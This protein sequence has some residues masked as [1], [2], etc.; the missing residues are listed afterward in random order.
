MP[1]MTTSYCLTLVCVALYYIILHCHQ[2]LTW[3]FMP[4]RH[5]PYPHHMQSWSLYGHMPY[6][7]Y[8]QFWSLHATITCSSW[9]YGTYAMPSLHAG[10]GLAWHMPYH[11]YMPL[12]NAILELII[13]MPCPQLLLYIALYCFA[14]L[15]ITLYYFVFGC[16]LSLIDTMGL[17]PCGL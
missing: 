7:H 16:T 13:H 17:I 3:A 12:V 10:L 11:H 9:A 6:P 15:C 2:S 1:S 4:S 5:V 8:M 14:L